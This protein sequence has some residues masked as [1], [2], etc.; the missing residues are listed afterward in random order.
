MRIIFVEDQVDN[1]ITDAY[2][3]ALLNAGIAIGPTG[4]IMRKTAV[5]TTTAACGRGTICNG[6]TLCEKVAT[7]QNA[8]DK[9]IIGNAAGFNAYLS[10]LVEFPNEWESI[11]GMIIDADM[12]PLEGSG[13]LDASETGLVLI[14]KVCEL[15]VPWMQ[16]HRKT[17]MKIY[18]LTRFSNSMKRLKDRSDFTQKN[19]EQKGLTATV[20]YLEYESA[21]K[22]KN[23]HDNTPLSYPGN[24]EVR[25]IQKE[26]TDT[27]NAAKTFV[28]EELMPW[29]QNEIERKTTEAIRNPGHK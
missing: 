1:K 24:I 23:E 16:L 29:M 17:G 15:L 9:N 10:F 3:R 20:S 7:I 13:S 25:F 12:K 6:T 21:D 5:C 11:S 19:A 4:D 2:R 28:E 26:S 18:L 14:E 8:L 22:H 27:D